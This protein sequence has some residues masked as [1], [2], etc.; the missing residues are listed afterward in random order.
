[1]RDRYPTAADVAFDLTNYSRIVCGERGRR[2]K[3]AGRVVRLKKW[4]RARHFEPAP[5]P[6]ASTPDGPAR[7]VVVA[8]AP[9]RPQDPLREA[10]RRPRRIRSER[11]GRAD[12]QRRAEKRQRRAPLQRGV[13]TSGRRGALHG[14]SAQAFRRR[15]SITMERRRGDGQFR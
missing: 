3:A 8:L 2:L 11:R 10:P 7:V 4:L 6:P 14:H 9:D 15:V 12:P 5:C 1:A 13:W